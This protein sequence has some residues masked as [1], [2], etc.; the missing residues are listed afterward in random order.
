MNSMMRSPP[1]PAQSGNWVFDPGSGQ[2]VCSPDCSGD[3]G[4][5][6][7]GPPVFSGPTQQPP[8]YPG[9]NGGVSFGA[10]PPPNPVRGHMFWDGTVFWLFDGAAWVNIGGLATP[11]KGVVDGSLAAPGYV[12]EVLRNTYTANITAVAGQNTTAVFVALN[13]TPGD[14]DV[15]G[16]IVFEDIT[17][18]NQFNF[19]ELELDSSSGT[20]GNSGLVGLYAPFG[21]VSGGGG[22]LSQFYIST[23]VFQAS[24]KTPILVSGTVTV[25]STTTPT[26][27]FSVL[28]AARRVR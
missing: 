16:R 5:P 12:G 21:P 20:I 18:A 27:T 4:F 6:P 9:A 26:A 8:W 28:T 23:N 24:N 14:W 10:T 3:G 2:W 22:S 7:F 11:I 15:Q 13:L 17:A 1:V 19:M 25:Q